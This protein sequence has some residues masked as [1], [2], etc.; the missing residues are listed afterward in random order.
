[1]DAATGDEAPRIGFG[2]SQR[3]RYGSRFN[4]F[5]NSKRAGVPVRLGC[6]VCRRRFPGSGQSRREWRRPVRSDL[7]AALNHMLD[8]FMHRTPRVECR[9]GTRWR[10]GRSTPESREASS[11]ARDGGACAKPWPRSGGCAR[12]SRRCVCRP[13]PVSAGGRRQG[14]SGAGVRAARV[15]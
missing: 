2:I 8:E 7:R 12:G 6:P 4:R 10:P 14:R 9:I 13:P 3:M 11:S 1:M 5:A 15:G